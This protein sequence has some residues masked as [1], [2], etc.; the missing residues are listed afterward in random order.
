MFVFT[1]G[2]FEHVVKKLDMNARPGC[3]LWCGGRNNGYGVTYM[4]GKSIQ[5]HIVTW[6]NANGRYPKGKLRRT[7]RSRTCCNPA[8]WVEN[9]AKCLRLQETHT[10]TPEN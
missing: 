8:H 3:W 4:H 2:L 10:P 6:A 9:I 5:A 1:P 7:C